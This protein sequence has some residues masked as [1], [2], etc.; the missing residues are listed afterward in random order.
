MTSRADAHIHL[1][2]GGYRDKSFASRPG[3]TIDE[4]VCYQSLASEHGVVAALA[5]GYTGDP[6]CSD[7]NDYLANLNSHHDWIKPVACI[8]VASPPTVHDLELLR[9]QGFVGVSLFVFDDDAQKL[10]HI[11]LEVWRW[12]DENNWLISV[13]SE[14]DRWPAWQPVLA[15][16][17]R[18]RL[19]ISHLGQPPEVTSLP[20]REKA[21]SVMSPVIELAK[22]P[23]VHVKLSGFYSLTSPGHDYPHATA[24]PYIEQLIECYSVTR[25]LWGSDFSPCL[26]WVTFPQT[27]DLFDRIPFLNAQDVEL[28]AGGNLVALFDEVK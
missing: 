7:N 11:S 24:W 17:P 15:S 6:W 28:I 22:Y 10:D 8:G 20:E 21:A 23:G 19:L 13:N 9:E 26:D 4:A 12:L 16:F 25:L 2:A 27:L 1:F 18:L 14:P 3:V 5:V